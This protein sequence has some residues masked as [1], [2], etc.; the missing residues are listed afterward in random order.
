MTRARLRLTSSRGRRLGFRQPPA[1]SSSLRGVRPSRGR[2]VHEVRPRRGAGARAPRDGRLAAH[3]AVRRLVCWRVNHSRPPRESPVKFVC[4]PRSH[5]SF[6]VSSSRRLPGTRRRTLSGSGDFR[7]ASA[8]AR[9]PWKPSRCGVRRVRQDAPASRCPL[10]AAFPYLRRA[11]HLR[12]SRPSHLC[13]PTL[14]AQL[15]RVANLQAPS[16]RAGPRDRSSQ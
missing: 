10:T 15:L 12:S 14:S 8:K 2:S 4:A 3:E 13:G 9:R 1:S 7:L 6:N 11:P 16:L 5:L